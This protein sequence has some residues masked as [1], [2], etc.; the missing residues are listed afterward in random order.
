MSLLV[1]ILINDPVVPPIKS[2]KMFKVL[3]MIKTLFSKPLIQHFLLTLQ[4]FINDKKLVV[5]LQQSVFEISSSGVACVSMA[6][7]F[8]PKQGAFDKQC[9]KKN[10]RMCLSGWRRVLFLLPTHPNHHQC[11][12]VRKKVEK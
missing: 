9:I 3:D 6:M 11:F 2:Q 12:G 10:Q 8:H 5:L 7:M 4:W 1:N